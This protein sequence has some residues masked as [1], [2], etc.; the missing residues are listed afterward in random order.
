LL[1]VVFE[2]CCALCMLGML[3]L[4]CCQLERLLNVNVSTFLAHAAHCTPC[5]QKKKPPWNAF[6]CFGF[7]LCNT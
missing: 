6:L 4:L 5:C 1:L 3:G 7:A 2:R